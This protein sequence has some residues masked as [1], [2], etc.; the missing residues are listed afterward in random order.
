LGSRGRRIS[1]F[2]AS[3]AYKVSYRTAKATQ[4]N[5]VLKQ[6]NK[7]TNK[8]TKTKKTGSKSNKKLRG[9]CRDGSVVKSTGCS[10][11][12]PE[13]NSQQLHGGSPSI[14]GSDALFWQQVSIQLD[15]S[16]KIFW[17]SL[18]EVDPVVCLGPSL[19]GLSFS[20]PLAPTSC[21]AFQAEI[22]PHR[23]KK[24]A[25][26]FASSARYTLPSCCTDSS[27]LLWYVG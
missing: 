23:N 25:S 3:L 20:R 2:E 22:C 27:A 17:A 1:E 15:H 11:R 10:S 9:G 5:P 12:D 6:T 4:R 19:E 26:Y 24:K 7:Q 21:A 14:L 13:F 18:N 8:Q 16:Y